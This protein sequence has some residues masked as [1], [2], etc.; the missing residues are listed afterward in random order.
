M[1]API[2]LGAAIVGLLA[3]SGGA[4][5]QARFYVDPDDGDTRYDYA[6]RYYGYGPQYQYAPPPAPRVYGYTNRF[7]YAPEVEPRLLPRPRGGC[8]LYRFWDGWRCVDAR[9]R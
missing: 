1:R 4:F 8:G 9:W 7:G 6:P 5:A 2:L 3:M